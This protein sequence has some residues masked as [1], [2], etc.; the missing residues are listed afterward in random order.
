VTILGKT[1]LASLII[2]SCLE[3][4]SSSTEI[5]IS[6]AYFYCAEGDEKRNDATSIFLGLL[7]QLIARSLDIEECHNLLPY[8]H[9]KTLGELS[10]S[11]ATT[12]TLLTCFCNTFPKLYLIIDGLDECHQDKRKQILTLVTKI[13]T[14]CD[15][16][17]PGKLRILILSRDLPDIRTA[18]GISTNLDLQ[19]KDTVT[20][21]TNYVKYRQ[22]LL[23][24]KFKHLTVEESTYIAKAVINNSESK[25]SGIVNLRLNTDLIKACF[26]LRNL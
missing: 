1:I 7:T 23:Q 8:C 19:R 25:C 12:E 24:R 18:L 3:K 14:I 2:D 6:T 22:E 26:C 16:K 5:P 9:D 4:T 21:I 17:E 20:D 10:P 13:I 15:N 11:F